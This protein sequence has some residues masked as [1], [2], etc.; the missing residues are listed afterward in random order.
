M[1]ADALARAEKAWAVRVAGGTWAQAAEVAGFSDAQHAQRAARN[2]FGDLPVVDREERRD[3]WRERFEAMWRQGQR[4][5]AEQRAGAVTAC[6]R[7]ATAAVALDGLNEA[8]RVDVEVTDAF[9]SL[10]KEL[11]EY[12]LA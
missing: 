11:T 4:D 9:G 5:M 1:R 3:V 6:V 12:G 10:V 7:V 2:V 8:V